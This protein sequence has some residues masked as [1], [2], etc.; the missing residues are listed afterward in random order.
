MR[1]PSGHGAAQAVD[2]KLRQ[3]LL[4][5]A[6]HRGLKIMAPGE[7]CRADPAPGVGDSDQD[8]GRPRG[9]GGRFFVHLHELDLLSSPAFDERRHR[10]AD[11][12]RLGT[13]PLSGSQ[14]AVRA[15]GGG[16]AEETFVAM[17]RHDP[18]PNLSAKNVRVAVL[19]ASD[20]AATSA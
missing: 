11:P 16:R 18:V 17:G 1:R 6:A 20:C 14:R 8:G 12:V 5:F 19:R 9:E 10:S 4:L 2:E 7:D 15:R 3:R 13:A